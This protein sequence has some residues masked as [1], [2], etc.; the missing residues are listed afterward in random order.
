MPA[1]INELTSSLQRWVCLSPAAR[2]VCV[3]LMGITM[4]A[5][6]NELTSLLQWWVCLVI[7]VQPLLYINK[8]LHK[9]TGLL[10]WWVLVCT[11]SWVHLV[12][13]YLDVCP[14][15]RPPACCRGGVLAMNQQRS[16]EAVL[17]GA[18]YR[19]VVTAEELLCE[20]AEVFSGIHVSLPAYE[21]VS[22]AAV[23]LRQGAWCPKLIGL[24]LVAISPGACLQTCSL[25]SFDPP[26][27]RAVLVFSFRL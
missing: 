12:Q 6:I 10:Q 16:K 9:P 25:D 7:C 20:D 1:T 23:L 8:Y 2:C 11:A 21:A 24:A 4:P 18:V 3:S 27:T 15:K 14:F 5:T 26:A 17:W 13:V 22:T 19:E